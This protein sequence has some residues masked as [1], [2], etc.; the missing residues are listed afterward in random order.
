MRGLCYD[1]CSLS[2]S[3]CKT[4][5]EPRKMLLRKTMN[6]EKLHEETPFSNCKVFF[7]LILPY[8]G[9][10]YI[11]RL[12]QASM[13]TRVYLMVIDISHRDRGV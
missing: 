13:P 5:F 3:F 11:L 12:P 6:E 8:P 2:T 4:G 9:P 7:F 1:E 10:L